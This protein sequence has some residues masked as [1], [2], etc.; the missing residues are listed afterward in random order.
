MIYY[1]L[2]GMFLS[3]AIIPR[4]HFRLAATALTVVAICV[5]GGLR[6]GVGTDWSS[7]EQVFELVGRGDSFSEFREETGFLLLTLAFN[8]ISNNYSVF[9]F[10]LFVISY[11]IKLYAVVKFKA[12]IIVSTIIY[13]VTIFLIYDVNGLRQGLAMGFVLCAGYFAVQQRLFLYLI[14]ISLAVSVHMVALVALPIYWMTNS[15]WLTRRPLAAQ[16]FVTAVL[17]ALGL[18]ISKVI[19]G[20]DAA[21][22]LEIFNLATRYTH[23]IDNF[24]KEFSILGLGS[25]QRLF[26]IGMILYMRETFD[27]TDRTKALLI[28]CY[29][30]S[31]FLFFVL[32]FN[33]EF[34]ARVSFY[35]KAFEIITLS[36]VFKSLK[37]PLP[38]IAFWLFLFLLTFGAIYQLLSAPDGGLLPYK[39]VLLR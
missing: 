33:L 28:N 1:L 13:F 11:S 19:G 20:T 21:V 2:A 25:M 5:F 7:Y 10:G 22:Y 27:C 35:Y 18:A 30:M 3:F 26:I 39:S 14:A 4:Q 32:S 8:F 37:R 16:Y 6:F 34:M 12:D 24:Q 15:T 31:T 36:I 17:I 38:R 23:Y 9:I 29:V